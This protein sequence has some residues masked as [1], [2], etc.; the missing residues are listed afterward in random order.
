MI[1]NE[2]VLLDP[3]LDPV[4]ELLAAFEERMQL[5]SIDR[6]DGIVTDGLGGDVDKFVHGQPSVNRIGHIAEFGF[7]RAG[8]QKRVG[9][10]VMGGRARLANK[11]EQPRGVLV[12]SIAVHLHARFTD[13]NCGEALAA[14]LT[15]AG[16]LPSRKPDHEQR[17]QQPVI[18]RAAVS[19]D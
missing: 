14:R 10:E 5:A 12:R 6:G 13:T 2:S 9:G 1:G 19:S 16:H 18:S 11:G 7:Q 3:G 8:D 17:H 15:M 4:P